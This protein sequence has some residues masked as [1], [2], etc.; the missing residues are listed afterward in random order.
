MLMPLARAL[1]LLVLCT[2][3]LLSAQAGDDP[4]REYGSA[5]SVAN[6]GFTA[7]RD[8]VY[9]VAWDVNAGPEAADGIVPGLR[10]PASFLLQADDNGIPRENVH[11]AIIVYGSATR[12]LLAN[13]A[14]RTATGSNN[15]NIRLLHALNEAGVQVIVCGEALANRNIPHDDLLPFV[16]VATSATMARAVLHAQGYAVFWP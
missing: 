14:Y 8:L 16:K 10:R 12:S 11:L 4:I 1:T 7:P 13:D 5:T 3:A 2:P 9:R 15:A 6:P